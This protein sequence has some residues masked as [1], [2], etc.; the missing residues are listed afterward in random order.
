MAIQLELLAVVRFNSRMLSTCYMKL[1]T[2]LYTKQLERWSSSGRV[3]LAQY[4]SDSIFVYQAYRP[5]IGNFAVKHGYFDGDFKLSRMTCTKTNFLWMMY[6][7][8]WGTKQGQ[9]VILAVRFQRHAFDEIL[10]TA[11]HSN[12]NPHVYASQEVWKKAVPEQREYAMSDTYNQLLTPREDVYP[13]N[14]AV[15]AARLGLSL[16]NPIASIGTQTKIKPKYSSK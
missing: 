4:D 8:G 10:L 16:S 6:R 7:S 2:E 3:I 1:Q 12:F 5:S 14:D 15:V 11:V 13:V 9:E